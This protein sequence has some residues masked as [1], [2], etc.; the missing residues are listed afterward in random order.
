[1]STMQLFKESTEWCYDRGNMWKYSEYVMGPFTKK[2][3]ARFAFRN[4]YETQLDSIDN[5]PKT[6]WFKSFLHSNKRCWKDSH[7]FFESSILEG[8]NCIRHPSTSF[9]SHHSSCTITPQACSGPLWWKVRT[10]RA[11]QW[12]PEKTEGC[13]FC[14]DPPPKK[15]K[16]PGQISSKWSKLREVFWGKN[17]LGCTFESLTIAA[18]CFVWKI[19]F[20]FKCF[21]EASFQSKKVTAPRFLNVWC[22]AN[23]KMNP[24]KA[25][26]S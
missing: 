19:K 15:H 1:M 17:M 8:E 9:K 24:W 14:H 20:T 22:F 2:Y 10:A 7:I 4:E 21:F 26:D 18:S 23:M 25:G 16:I 11:A 13:D 5:V 12:A 3:G 6:K